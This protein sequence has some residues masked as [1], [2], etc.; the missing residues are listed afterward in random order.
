MTCV[1]GSGWREDVMVDSRLRSL[2]QRSIFTQAFRT[3][4]IF[5]PA[6]IRAGFSSILP[7]VTWLINK[8]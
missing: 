2:L 6:V 1:N 4:L 5:H 3:N 8:M 7:N